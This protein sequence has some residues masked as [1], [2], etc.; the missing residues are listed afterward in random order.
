[1]NDYTKS[2]IDLSSTSKSK[3][4]KD[5]ETYIDSFNRKIPLKQCYDRHLDYFSQDKSV[6]FSKSEFFSSFQAKNFWRDLKDCGSWLE[7]RWYKN[8]DVTKL[9]TANFCKRDKLCVACAVRRAYKQQIKFLSILEED[10]ELK[11][12]DWYYIVLPVK[13]TKKESLEVVLDRVADLR[14]KITQRMRDHRKGKSTNFFSNFQ[15]G[16]FAQEVTHTKNGWNVHLNLLLNAPKGSKIN[17]KEIRNK[18]GQISHQNEDLRQFMLKHF[19]SQMHDIQKLDFSSEEEIRGSLVEILKYALKFSSLSNQ[20]LIE[21]FIKTRKKRLFGTFGNLWGKGLEKVDLDK[22]IEL[23]QEFLELIFTRTFNSG[24]VEYKLYKREVKEIQKKE[25]EELV[26]TFG[27]VIPKIAEHK[28]YY[29]SAPL[30]MVKTGGGAAKFNI[31]K[32]E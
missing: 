23:D 15:G 5:I 32:K 4:K 14:A 9:H 7:F 3:I 12:K 24:Q 21:V 13:H 16:M 22:D 8:S 19:E 18:R 30:I 10:Q 26:H 27:I 17:L 20:E 2:I 6:P 28:K 29:R 31:R 11:D 25:N 1:M